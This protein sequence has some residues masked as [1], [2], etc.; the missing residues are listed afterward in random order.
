MLAFKRKAVEGKSVLDLRMMPARKV[1]RG[2]QG[3]DDLERRSMRLPVAQP[4]K[5]Y[6]G[7]DTAA[8]S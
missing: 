3:K 1:S 2:Q 6:R 7:A 4:E 5:A 8:Q